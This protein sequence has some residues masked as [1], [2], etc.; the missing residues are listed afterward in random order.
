[1]RKFTSKIALAFGALLLAAGLNT[2]KAQTGAALNFDGTDRVM[3]P[4]SISTNS[5]VG[6]N[7][8]CVEAWAKPISNTGN[9]IVVGNYASPNPV[10]QFMLRRDGTSWTFFLGTGN[11][12]FS[13]TPLVANSA[14]LNTW[15]HIAGVFNGT[16]MTLYINGVATSSIATSNTFAVSNN[17]ALIGGIGGEYFQGDIDEVRIWSVARTKCE[18][19]TFMNCEIPSSSTGLLA[20]YHFNQGVAAAAN[21]TVTTLTDFS[22]NA[23]T[24]TLTTFALTGPTSNWVTP[25]GVVSGFTTALAPPTLTVAA[26]PALSTCQNNT[27]SLTASGASTYTWSGGVTN[28]VAF[29]AS[30]TT[31]YTV[32]ATAATGCTASSVANVTTNICPGEALSFDGVNDFVDCGMT[33]TNALKGKDK[34]TVEAWVYPTQNTVGKSLVGNHQSLTQ[35]NIQQ[36]TTNQFNFFIGFGSYSATTAVNSVTLNTWHHVVGVFDDTVLKIY[37]NGVL[38]STTAVPATY[39]LDVN[40][41]IPVRIGKSGF[42][43]E[44]FKG[45]I[46]E[47]RI[48]DTVRTQCQIITYKNCEIPTNASH[49]LVNYHLNQGTAFGAN[50][51]VTIAND[52]TSSATNGTLTN[53]A[54]TAGSNNSNWV[55]PGGVVSGFT[56]ALAAPG[57]TNSALAVCPGGTVVLGST[58]ATSYTW[59]PSITNNAPFTPTAST[60]YSYVGTNSVST[61][62]NNAV[63]NVT[64]IPNPTVTAVTSETNVLCVGQSATLTA[65]GGNTY[66]WNTTATTAVIAISPTVTTTYTVTGTNANGCSNVAT[67]TQSVSACTGIANNANVVALEIYPNPSNGVFNIK[68]TSQVSIEVFDVLGNSILKTEI[69]SGEYKLNL[70]EQSKGLYIFKCASQGQ[71]KSYRL[72]KD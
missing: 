61:C 70:G 51:T 55:A 12:T 7:Q 36:L 4:L 23:L 63:I 13:Q 43:G 40:C 3:L 29:T 5:L 25:G 72:I 44:E 47:V 26:N 28:A 38:S 53:F 54:L 21:P 14:T 66:V 17:T 1:M 45:I 49:L 50:A 16:V 41:A 27:I 58:N 32:N 52:A 30:A 19:N 33:I 10:I 37:L 67:V 56:T 39:S 24:G 6:L 46:D 48:W 34:L 8:I 20:N 71:V 22:G 11:T 31:A 60:T 68:A 18:I 15:Q 9:G 35:F 57:Y 2:T 62:S 69:V 59:T 42:G 64:V 65:S